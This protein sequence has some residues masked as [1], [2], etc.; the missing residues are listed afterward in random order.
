MNY[1]C[2]IILSIL[3]PG[4]G[5]MFIKKVKRAIIFIIS[6]L[7][8]QIIFYQFLC[9][10]FLLFIVSYL[11]FGFVQ[12]IALIDSI[13]TYKKDNKSH[14]IFFGIIM[15]IFSIITIK[16]IYLDNIARLYRYRPLI[17]PSST[18]ENTLFKEDRII[19][20]FNK[21]YKNNIERN[22]IVV[23]N[24]DKNTIIFFRCIAVENDKIKIVNDDVYLN[25]NILNEEYKYLNKS[26]FNEN[27]NYDFLEMTIEKNMVFLLGDNRYNSRDSRFIGQVSND[28]I[29][30]KVLF[31]Y[32]K[33]N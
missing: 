20:D 6:A 25:E 21:N 14:K 29:I 23:Y 7:L 5:H 10:N 12:I 33:K 3:W 15:L 18:M 1:L 32:N 24:P 9:F 13:K 27:I 19:C 8:I 16:F 26:I 4:L 17:I 31:R 22:D 11:V 2:I 28:K 30:G